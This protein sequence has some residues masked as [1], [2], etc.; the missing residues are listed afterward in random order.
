MVV[1]TFIIV[2]FIVVTFIVVTIFHIVFYC[3][4]SKVSCGNHGHCFIW[5]PDTNVLDDAL[6]NN[7]G[8]KIYSSSFFFIIYRLFVDDG[9]LE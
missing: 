3:F 5:N 6:R 8:V 7:G 2:T 1:I 9:K 4:S